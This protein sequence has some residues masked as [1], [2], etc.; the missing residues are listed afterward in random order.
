VGLLG[1]FL[2][3]GVSQAFLWRSTFEALTYVT[4]SQ[5]SW[6]LLTFGVAW[7]F[8]EGRVRAGVAAGSLTGLGLIISYY[9]MQWV[10][11]GR[12]SALAQFSKTGGVAWT[13]AAV[14]GGALMGLF[15]GLASMKARER[16]RMKALGITT[17]AVIVGVG[18]ATWILVNSAYLDV[19][20]SL[21]AVA[22]F[23]LV[24]ASLVLVAARTC[25]RTAS[26]QA[27]AIAVGISTVALAGLLILETNGWLYLTF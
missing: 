22:V 17:P 2:I 8:A 3:G 6:V 25:G 7:A 10:A 13:V 20:R 16:P 4:N 14:G 5:F 1:A 9:A 11:D 21:P 18:P 19:S 12:H 23:V 27:V 15:G 24:G 26:I